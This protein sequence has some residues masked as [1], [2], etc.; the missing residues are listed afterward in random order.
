MRED[1]N[2]ERATEDGGEKYLAYFDANNLYGYALSQPLPYSDFEWRIDL[3]MLENLQKIY[4][5]YSG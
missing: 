2:L 1:I 5:L 3:E 4:S